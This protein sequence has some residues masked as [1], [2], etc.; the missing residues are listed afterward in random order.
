MAKSPRR[1]GWAAGSEAEDAPTP[2]AAV[3]D[4]AAASAAADVCGDAAIEGGFQGAAQ[5]QT[6][7]G[8]RVES[9]VI[10][11]QKV[12]EEKRPLNAVLSWFNDFMA[13]IT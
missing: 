11:S 12:H 4:P 9:S 1:Q 13:V 8:L 2:S 5:K 6:E 10:T 7:R 3:A